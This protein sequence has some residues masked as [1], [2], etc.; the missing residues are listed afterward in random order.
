MLDIPS[1]IDIQTAHERIFHQ[2]HCTP[3][4][5]SRTMDQMVG[6]KLFFKCENF[7]RSGSF[8]FR[9]A[10]N[11][12][13]SLDRELAQR[14]VITHS[15]GNHAAALALAA[16]LHEVPA[17]IVI[18]RDAPTFKIDA[19]RRYGGEVVLCEPTL[20]ARTAGVQALQIRS[21]GTLVHPYDD[22]AVIAGQG[23]AALEL[24]EQVADLDC[25]VVPISGGGLIS[26]TAIAIK[27][28]HPEVDVFGAEPALA[29][30]ARRSLLT[31][32]LQTQS[33]SPTI[34]D[35]LRANLSPRTFTVIQQ[36]VAE[37]FTVTEEEILRGMRWISEVL[38][39][40]AEPSGA[41]PL[42]V[43]LAQGKKFSGKRIGIVL[44]GGNCG[45][46]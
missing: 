45:L 5:Q 40:I 33:S 27:G 30:D 26:G 35:G 31:G 32:V 25:V 14:G 10:S 7:Q 34:A 38:K 36:H 16:K 39:V 22:P 41:V 9:G 6:A 28:I 42:A 21:G 8:K 20:E 2:V 13:L 17:T 1:L 4:L 19:V 23:T 46:S 43:V 15:S 44:S 11:A 29:D 3:V 24:I 37:I 18:P 12:I